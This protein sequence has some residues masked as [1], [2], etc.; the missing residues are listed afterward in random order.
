MKILWL[1]W[2]DRSHPAAG[3]AEVVQDNLAKRLVADGH[4]VIALVAGFP[5][6]TLT[7]ERNGY[8]S[9]RLGNKWNVYFKAYQYYRQHLQDWPDVIIDEM[10]TIPF[11]AGFYAKQKTI[12]FV[13]QLC[14]EIWFYQM[15]FPLNVIGYLLEP[16]YLWSLRK[17]KVITISESTKQDLM[18]YGFKEANISII[19]EGIE[20][21]PVADLN[22]EEKFP[23][24]TMLCLGVFREMKRTDHVV[25]AFEIA[26]QTIPN[27][28]LVLAGDSEGLYAQSVLKAIQDSPYR[29][30]IK[31]AGKVDAEYKIRL[32]RSAHVLCVASVKEGWGLVVT[33]ANSQGT[34]AV[35]YN[36]DGLRDSVRH[37][38]T[39]YVTPANT[40]EALAQGVVELLSDTEQYSSLQKNAWEWSREIT[41]EKG[42]REFLKHIKHA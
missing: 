22:L 16:I 11:F 32:Y 24:P 25:R 12:L 41:F 7:E 30:D 29:A 37:G 21:E 15:K 33:E 6:C 2:K 28:E 39:G 23:N 27:L 36:V 13:H 17:Q 20:I 34:P 42:Y 18:R 31:Y 38:V 8:T 19:S 4:E 3:G 9:V 5:G 10:N 40:P 35:V 14:R 26:K 1:H